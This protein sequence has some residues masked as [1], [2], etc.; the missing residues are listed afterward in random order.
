MRKRWSDE[1]LRLA[2]S[3]SDSIAE[4]CGKLQLNLEG[5]S[6][7]HVRNHIVRMGLDTTHFQRVRQSQALEA[8]RAKRRLTADQVLCEKS[9][10]KSGKLS[11]YVQKF[12]LLPYVCADCGN[13][14]SHNGK[15]LVLQIDHINGVHDDNRLHNLRFMCPNCHSQTTTFAG[16]NCRKQKVAVQRVQN[17]SRPR[18]VPYATLA[19]RYA[20]LLNF[21]AVGKEFGVSSPTV[22]KAVLLS[23]G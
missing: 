9:H 12:R 16:R 20:E 7:S 19:A 23:T 3:T 5:G 10:V 17:R 18:K 6:H 21:E 13:T 4:V 11:L 14:G 1:D 22:K 2:V 8:A 15:V